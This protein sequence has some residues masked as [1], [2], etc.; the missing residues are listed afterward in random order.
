MTGP[1]GGVPNVGTFAASDA[2][3][4][5]PEAIRTRLM[6]RNHD[7]RHTAVP[8]H[9]AKVLIA[10]RAPRHPSLAFVPSKQAGNAVTTSFADGKEWVQGAFVLPNEAIPDETKLESFVVPGARLFFSQ[11]L[12][13]P[14]ASDLIRS[15][16]IISRGISILIPPPF[17]F[18]GAVEAVERSAGLSLL[19]EALKASNVKH[20]CQVRSR[21]C[22]WLGFLCNAGAQT[23]LSLR[24]GSPL[25][26]FFC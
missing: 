13:P 25:R 12:Y 18:S 16:G 1:Q 11:T 10:S 9:F 14:W 2:N 3:Q 8:T 24:G 6:R 17:F 23:K 20:L 5:V 22:L 21:L 15:R 4:L 19:P 7:A 26:L